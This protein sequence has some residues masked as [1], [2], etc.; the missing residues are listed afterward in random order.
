MKENPTISVIV[1]VYN[2]EKFLKRCIRSIIAQTY[3]DLEIIIVNDSSTDNSQ[4]IIDMFVTEDSR[5]KCVKHEVNRGLFQAR[6]TGVQASTGDY[7]A[8][9]DSDDHVSIDWFRLLI[10]KALKTSSDITIGEWCFEYENGYREYLNL[11]P[12]RIQD[13]DFSGSNV[14]KNFMEQEELCFSWH[15]VWNK[16]YSRSLW[17]K[18]ESDFVEFS[19]NHGHMLMWEDV[20]FSSGF[21]NYANRVVNVHGANY[22]YFKHQEASTGQ[23]S[24]KNRN[25]GLKYIND[26]FS[27]ISFMERLLKKSGHYMQYEKEYK[28]WYLRCKYT[29][30]EDLVV[31]LSSKAYVTA[32]ES[33][34]GPVE[35]TKVTLNNFFYDLKTQLEDSFK[36]L[37]DIKETISSDETEVVSFDVFDTLIQRPFFEPTDLFGILSDRFNELAETSSYVDFKSI[38]ILAE[39]ECRKQYSLS[40]PSIEDI[41]F[42]EIYEYIANNYCFE[43]KIVD[44]IKKV[45][46]ELEYN[47]CS[48]RKIGKELYELAQYCNKR[49]ILCSDMYLSSKAVS[50]ILKKNGYSAHEALYVSSE[51]KLTKHT[52]RIFDFIC[53]NLKISMKERQHCFHIGDNWQADVESPI[54]KGWKAAHL[55]KA[56]DIFKG[57][58]SG[59]YSGEFFNNTF[60]NSY[61]TIDTYW[62]H[63]DFLG[64]SGV[65]GLIANRLFDNPFVSI[66][67]GTDFNMNPYTIGYA[68]LGPHLLALVQWIERNRIELE[69]EKIH[70]VARDGYLV[71]KA[72][73]TY[74]GENGHSNYIRL[75][76]KSLLLADVN[77][78][79]DLYSI[80]T[81]ANIFNM[82]P[83]KLES[84]LTPILSEETL[85]DIHKLLDNAKLIYDRKFVSIIEYQRALKIYIENGVDIKR[86]SKY[87]TNLKTYFSQIINPKD[88]LFDIGYSGRPE[89]ALSNLLG[90]PVHSLYVHTLK[91]IATK[92][93]SRFDCICKT[94]YDYKPVITGV[95]REHLL[96]ELG[97]STIGYKEENGVLSP[98]L[99]GK[100]IDYTVKYVTHV[101]QKAALDFIKDYKQNFETYSQYLIARGCDLSVPLEYY[102]HNSKEWD[103]RIFSTLEFEDDMGEGKTL[104]ALEF[105]NNEI[106]KRMQGTISTMNCSDPLLSNLYMDGLFIKFYKKINKICPYGSK[107]RELLKKVVRMFIR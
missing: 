104:S 99:E 14:I 24:I 21:W 71:K 52:G 22:F 96:M 101:L 37:E 75:S 40:H 68:V 48:T 33:K 79:D 76:R 100:E 27:A 72:Y 49:I 23:F 19:Q 55:P 12:F 73:D 47:L 39:S 43:Q 86:L 7:I 105:W 10:N 25:R 29:V 32:L 59:I 90:Y 81:K 15:V 57:S 66:N 91:D 56:V 50:A 103:R 69:S 18:C 102:L 46:L 64:L 13:V 92:R 61:H 80:I 26:S 38:R 88:L 107:K 77:S 98:V 78:V 31:R 6:I 4:D 54:A 65:F 106:S 53:K 83:R 85:N 9:V 74:Y 89:A 70:F 58:N 5:V 44:A 36:W 94:F 87:Q 1:P 11:D 17:D 63:H 16:L 51:I 30:Y 45:E 34:F 42:D 67:R 62:A 97:P 28:N 8:F 93:Q 20:A 41:S 60:Q 2:T 3:K 35:K 82:S 84:F 95:M